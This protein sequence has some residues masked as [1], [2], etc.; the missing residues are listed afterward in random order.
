MTA[1]ARWPRFGF[2]VLL[3]A[4]AIVVW[5]YDLHLALRPS[6]PTPVAEPMTYRLRGPVT[7]IPYPWQSGPLPSIPWRMEAPEVANADGA[8][9]SPTP[10]PD[11]ELLGISHAEGREAALLRNRG[12]GET[13]LLRSRESAHGVTLVSADRDSVT[14]NSGSRSWRLVLSS[15]RGGQR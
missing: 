5:G 7:P 3:V 15:R 4:L 9:A 2:Q 8:N 11:L 12:T 14:L 13:F 1:R 6:Q 10:I